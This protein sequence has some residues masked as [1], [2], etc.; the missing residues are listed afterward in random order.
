[1]AVAGSNKPMATNA[2]ATKPLNA[3]MRNPEIMIRRPSRSLQ[4]TS[5]R[6]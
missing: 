1:L 3:P 6:F 4:F 5:R 2:A